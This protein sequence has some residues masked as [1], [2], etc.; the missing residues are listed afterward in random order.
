MKQKIINLAII[1]LVTCGAYA[2][3]QYKISNQKFTVAGTSNV[4]DWTMV[5]QQASGTATIEIEEG[6]ITQ[7]TS[8]K[9]SIPAES[10]KSEKSG[11]DKVAYKALKTDKYSTITFTLTEIKKVTVKGNE[12]EILAEGVLNLSGVERKYVMN[13]KGHVK[14]G[15]VIFEGTVPVKMTNHKI[16]PPTA[17]FGTVKSGDDTSVS[18]RVVFAQVSKSGQHSAK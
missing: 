1:L 3:T 13:V 14:D 4:H 15:M 18:F 11:M 16:D 5:S 10:L 9:L 2:Q 17:L 7:I 8:L 6:K 12:A